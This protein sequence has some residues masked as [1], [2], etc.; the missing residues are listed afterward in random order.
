MRAPSFDPRN[1]LLGVPPDILH[2][3]LGMAC[4]GR[5]ETP[6]DDAH[7]NIWEVI[8]NYLADLK[9]VGALRLVNKGHP[10]R[11]FYA[12]NRLD[13][14]R[15]TMRFWGLLQLASFQHTLIETEF[16]P[17]AVWRR[18]LFRRKLY[19]AR[20]KARSYRTMVLAHNVQAHALITLAGEDPDAWKKALVAL[21]EAVRQFSIL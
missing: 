9:T 20:D 6:L 7:S 8:A 4:N 1:L 2:K 12:P 3:I 5:V 16:P 15:H 21:K 13:Y 17:D 14:Y 11:T 18:K 10:Y 19:L